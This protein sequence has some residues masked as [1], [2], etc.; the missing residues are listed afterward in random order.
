VVKCTGIIVAVLIGIVLGVVIGVIMLLAVHCVRHRSVQ[1]N[2]LLLL[3]FPLSYCTASL[4]SSCKAELSVNDLHASTSV[5]ENLYLVKPNCDEESPAAC[6]VVHRVK[7]TCT[8][9]VFSKDNNEIYLA[10]G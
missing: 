9:T 4:E 1:L 7:F 2:N 10:H 8:V 3:T 6:C 5:P